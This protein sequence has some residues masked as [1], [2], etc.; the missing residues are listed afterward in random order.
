MQFHIKLLTWMSRNC[1]PGRAFRTRLGSGLEKNVDP[2]RS[3]L[4]NDYFFTA[5]YLAA[6]TT[7]DCLHLLVQA[8]K[9]I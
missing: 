6:S 8:S 1:K 4:I 9:F 5:E 2:V 7:F 3:L